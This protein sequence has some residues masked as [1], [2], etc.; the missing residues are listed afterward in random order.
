[1][2]QPT[3]VRITE[4]ERPCHV[5][6]VM[7]SEVYYAESKRKG[8]G[9]GRLIHHFISFKM[10][11]FSVNLPQMMFLHRNY[12]GITSRLVQFSLDATT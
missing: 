4:Q 10:T 2:E 3:R 6:Y 11:V 5:I 7:N 1:M 9:N 8:G 12:S